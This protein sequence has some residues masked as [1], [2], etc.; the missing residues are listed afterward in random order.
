MAAT[1]PG[2]E[3]TTTTFAQATAAADV[4]ARF[5][6]DLEI[7]RFSVED[8]RTLACFFTTVERTAQAGKGKALARAAR[9][10]VHVGTPYRSPAEALAAETGD[11]VGE[12]KDLVQLAETLADQPEVEQAFS[13]GTLSRRR[14][15][16]VAGA[17]KADP[18]KESELVD[19]AKTESEAQL[20]ERCLRV[21]AAA[22]SEED[23]ERHQRRLHAQRKA[24]TY[25][26]EDGAVCLTATFTPGVGAE[27]TA[28]I[29]AQADRQFEQ[30]RRE[31]RE[32][33]PAA[34]RADAVSALLTG[35]GLV[36]PL[37]RSQGAPATPE[38]TS[39]GATRG[40]GTTGTPST[41]SGPGDPAAPASPTERSSDPKAT[42]SVVIDLEALRRGQ[43]ADGERCEIPGV[44]P[45]PVTYAHD[46][47]GE[48]LVELLIARGTD[49]TTVYSAGRHIPQRVRSALLLRDPR[50]VVPGCD[51]RLGLE[52]DHWVTDYAEG[53][54]T[55]LD[56]L[57][58]LCRRHHRDRTHHGF[59]LRKDGDTWIWIA[60]A[61]PFTPKRPKRKRKTGTREKAPP[62]DPEPEPSLF[63]EESP[64]RKE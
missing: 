39:T 37:G 53:G 52:N 62:P 47:L 14:A 61:Q 40:N 12:T 28:A 2:T 9:A 42:L 22:R 7:D 27:V 58:R 43:V 63:D 5:V 30:A 36:G 18:D 51:A 8:S 24:R 6:A 10:D 49:V 44:G 55:S 59:E 48:A 26:D 45:V 60:P 32:E 50:C 35:K 25:T 20:K 17:V 1:A 57:A 21:K 23:E 64:P 11:S 31:G 15:A 41:T 4:F 33:S 19:A 54:L 34:Y 56:N 3:R 38:S 29:E 13:D 46:L 16:L